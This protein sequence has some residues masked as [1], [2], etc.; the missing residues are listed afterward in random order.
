[1]LD[2]HRRP[3]LEH[4]LAVRV[5][6]RRQ[7]GHARP[8]APRRREQLEVDLG[9][10]GEE[11]TGADERHGSGH[12]RSLAAVR[13]PRVRPRHA[14]RERDAT[15]GAR[16]TLAVHDIRQRWTLVATIIGSGVVFLDGTIVNVALKRIGQD[17]PATAI[18]PFEGQTYVVSGYLAVLA[19]LLILVGGPVRPLRAP[20]RSTR[21]ASRASPPRPRCAAWR[22]RS[23]GWS[24]SGCS[25][26]RPGA[27]LVPG[28]L[29]LITHAFEGPERGLARSACGPPR[30]RR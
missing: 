6:R 1:M 12:A 24:S 10:R 27:L 26:A 25:R 19:A 30:P 29:A 23:S 7:D 9:H 3:A 21:S 13:R 20:A 28:S 15:V 16:A 5:R 4:L 11:F 18:S 8:R 17:L 2:A 14:P 22:R